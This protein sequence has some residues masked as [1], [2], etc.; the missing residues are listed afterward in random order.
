M[1]NSKL[2]VTGASGQ[3]GRL[4]LHHLLET[5]KVPASQIVATTR[6]PEALA[7]FAARGIEVRPADFDDPASLDKAFAGVDRLLLVST[8]E[9]M[10]PGQRLIQHQNAVA[11]AERAGVK[12]VIYTSMPEPEG[13]PILFAPDH[14]GTE[15]A[16]AASSLTW[17]ILRNSWYFENLFLGLDSI[18]ATGQWFTAAEAGRTANV[19]REDTARA[20]AAVLASDETANAIYTLTGEKA[21]T[22]EEVAELLGETIGKPIQVVHLPVEALVQGM[23]DHGVPEAFARVVA[24]FDVNAKQDRI[25]TVTDDFRKL[26]GRTPQTFADWFKENRSAILSRASQ[27]AGLV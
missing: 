11:A 8:N 14:F 10:R 18:L 16:L 20:A 4:V 7:D 5:E 21:Y 12:H 24:S 2:L 27:P 15:Q 3:L 23:V 25:S 22:V 9:L 1:S 26:T 19:G 17:T 6:T 13:S